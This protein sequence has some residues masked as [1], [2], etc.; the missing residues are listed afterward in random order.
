M[1]ELHEGRELEPPRG[2]LNIVDKRSWT[3]ES[4]VQEEL[5]EGTASKRNRYP[6]YVEELLNKLQEKD[7]KLKEFIS[8][9]QEEIHLENESFRARLNREMERRL[10]AAKADLVRGFLEVLDNLERA[11]NSARG[12]RDRFGELFKGIELVKEQF[13]DQ[14]KDQG[15]ERLTRCGRTFD[16]HLEEALEAVAV[17][18]DQDNLVLEEI[19]P[20]YILGEKLIR[21]AK[22]KV[23]RYEGGPRFIVA[24]E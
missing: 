13:I 19:E 10:E 18:E 1:E 21:P 17:G 24:E 12:H 14:L 15:I 7:R 5:G 6:T 16:P 23:G 4:S 11:L 8:S 2:G 3:Q 20:G 9:Y 22:V